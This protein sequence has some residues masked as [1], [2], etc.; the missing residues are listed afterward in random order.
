[1]TKKTLLLH[2][3]MGKTGTTA[4]Q[5]FFWANREV[6]AE[7]DVCYPE[8]GSQSAA[9]HLISPSPLQDLVD[10]GWKFLSP[11]DWIEQVQALPQSRILMSSELMFSTAPKDVATFLDAVRDA[12]EVKI[13]AYLRRPDNAIMAAF[14]QQAKA[15]TQIRGID[16]VLKARMQNFAYLDVLKHWDAG[17]AAMIVRPYERKQLK[18]GDIIADFL[19]HILGIESLDGFTIPAREENAN[20]RFATL[21][22]DFKVMINNL[23]P[24]TTAS[25]KFNAP[26]IAYSE[27]QDAD[28]QAVFRDQ[29]TLTFEQRA[30]IIEYF[31][32]QNA[33]IASHYLGRESGQLFDETL[34]AGGAKALD[35]VGRAQTR[36]KIAEWISTQSPDLAVELRAAIERGVTSKVPLIRHAAMSLDVAFGQV[37]LTQMVADEAASDAERHE[38]SRIARVLDWGRGLIFQRWGDKRGSELPRA[39]RAEIVK[40]RPLRRI[41]IHPGFPKT[42]T[43]AI[44]SAFHA[45]RKALLAEYQVLYPGLEENHTKPIFA[46]FAEDFVDNA[47]FKN[48]S[49]AEISEYQTVVRGAFDLELNRLDW[50]VLVIS[51]EGI[52]KMPKADWAKL[53]AYLRFWA[54]RVDV[55]Y[56]V[57]SPLEFTRSAVQQILKEGVT[58]EAI[59]ADPPFQNIRVNVASAMECGAKIHFWNFDAAVKSPEGMLQ[60]F[61]DH[62]G[63]PKGLG[64]RL[65]LVPV[66][67]NE[68]LSAQGVAALAKRN[69]ALATPKLVTEKEHD[70][71]LAIKGDKFELPEEVALAVRR[72]SRDD[73]EWMRVTFGA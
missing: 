14:N 54:D 26:L 9:H 10:I 41:I 8:I 17:V 36:V 51:G 24:D 44:Q 3:G 65:K 21:A 60:S 58:L 28:T 64:E 73:E 71:F 47:R 39:V 57:R 6:L 30:K 68:S 66:D 70:A 5:E 19:S 42:G 2:I 12:F 4:L 49:E 37:L 45:E 33:Y 15:G 52:Q 13:I 72:V 53:M 35:E 46:M 62:L 34:S 56:A 50:R 11:K 61:T 22:L 23:I 48:M 69:A 27:A 55:H 20:P 18:D 40:L 29:D 43:T 1:M 7:H 67:R 16:A 63:L 38:R 31:R 32:E 59:Y 25:S